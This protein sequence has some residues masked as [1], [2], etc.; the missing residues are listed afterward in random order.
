[1][2]SASRM[3]LTLERISS[4][5]RTEL[6][7]AA[8]V[9]GLKLVQLEALIFLSVA[10]RYSDTAGAMGE[11]LGV[12][13]GTASQTLLALERRG[14]IAKTPDSDDGRVQHCRLTPDGAAIVD[15]T[16]PV[17]FL[18]DMPADDLVEG[19]KVATEL[20]RL[21]QRGN[22]F[23]AFGQCDGCAHFKRQGTRH[24]C[25]LTRERLSRRDAGRICRE[26]Q[27]NAQR[28]PV[29]P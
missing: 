21:L 9:H 4:L 27:P 23:R 14:L 7:A 2:H 22:S 15:S 1:M 16:H 18:T 10:N 29:V 8:S 5:F 11:Y 28:L 17:A 20:L 25:G 12:T 26:H 19:E 24:R 3:H 13:K 6:R